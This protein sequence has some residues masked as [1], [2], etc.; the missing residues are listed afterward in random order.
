MQGLLVVDCRSWSWNMAMSP[1]QTS[2][3]APS[4]ETSGFWKG[5]EQWPGRRSAWEASLV[6]WTS[7]CAL[8]WPAL[9][10]LNLGKRQ[11]GALA[12]SSILF[13]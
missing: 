5:L 10:T 4:T 3:A 13:T 8:R 11:D 12:S 6:P 9:V 7:S 1:R 2:M